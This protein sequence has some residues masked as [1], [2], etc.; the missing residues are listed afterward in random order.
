MTNQ[1]KSQI[2]NHRLNEI[3]NKLKN[4]SSLPFPLQT[5]EYKSILYKMKNELETTEYTI[6]IPSYKYP[7]I[8]KHIPDCKLFLEKDKKGNFRCTIKSNDF[9]DLKRAITEINKCLDE[10]FLEFDESKL[11][12]WEKFYIWWFYHNTKFK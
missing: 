9:R 1:Q 6:N 2:T 8:P 12:E 7:L 10:G 4:F 3:N 11:S 5:P